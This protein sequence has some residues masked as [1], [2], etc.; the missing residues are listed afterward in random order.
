MSSWRDRWFAELQSAMLS[1]SDWRKGRLVTYV[2]DG[3]KALGV[4]SKDQGFEKET[5]SGKLF[6]YT[7]NSRGP[8]ILP[9]GT[10]EDTGRRS[11]RTLLKDTHCLRSER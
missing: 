3:S 2:F 7:R 1:I 8:R 11:E 10:P 4:I 5:I 9:W 6:M